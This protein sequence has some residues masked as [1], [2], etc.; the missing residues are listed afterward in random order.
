MQQAR[1]LPSAQA[2][3]T[4]RL[5][6]FSVRSAVLL[7][8]YPHQCRSLGAKASKRMSAIVACDLHRESRHSVQYYVIFG[9]MSV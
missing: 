8:R 2:D 6:G 3:T 7:I 9:H 1:G 5:Y 4:A